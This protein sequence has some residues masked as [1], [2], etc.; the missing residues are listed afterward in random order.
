MGR[1]GRVG[2]GGGGED[3]KQGG[4]EAKQEEAR[5][6]EGKRGRGGGVGPQGVGADRRRYPICHAALSHERRPAA[7]PRG[8]AL[9]GPGRGMKALSQGK[10]SIAGSRKS[11]MLEYTLCWAIP[12]EKEFSI[13]RPKWPR[14]ECWMRGRIHIP[15]AKFRRLQDLRIREKTDFQR[16]R[17]FGAVEPRECHNESRLGAPCRRS[18]VSRKASPGCRISQL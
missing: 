6:G 2:R 16:C 7:P 5:G 14:M 11:V 4:G 9:L 18:Q 15:L 12:F 8:A 10:V 13:R 17:T 1:V 3:G